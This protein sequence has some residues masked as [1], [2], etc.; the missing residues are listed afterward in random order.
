MI[1][2]STVLQ[3]RFSQ[4]I[5]E[6]KLF[7]PGDRLIVALSGGADSTALLHLLAN[8]DDFAP[9]LVVG[10]LNHCLRGRESDD[11]EVF[12]RELAASFNL[13][14]VT[15]RIDVKEFA[16]Q[17]RLNLEDAGR[18]ARADF[19]EEIRVSWQGTAIAVAHHG[20]DQAETVLM[21]L[22]RGAGPG[23]LRGMS[24]RNERRVIRPLLNFTRS[25]IETY[26]LEQ[27]LSYRKDSSNL[28]TSFLRN[29]IRH[30]LMPLL[31]DYNPAIRGR[32]NICAGQLS[33]EDDLL[34]QYTSALMSSCCK[35]EDLCASCNIDLLRK[36]HPA[37]RKRLY[38]LI[39]KEIA[40]SL[41]H[42][43]SL[44]VEAIDKLI[45][46]ERSNAMLNLP[47]KLTVVREYG[48][49]RFLGEV[50]TDALNETVISGPGHYKL[51]NTRALSLDHVSTPY[52]YASITADTAIFDLD[53]VPFPWRVRSF[54]NG[55]RIVPLGMNGSKKLKDLF[56]DCKVPVSQRRHTPLI[57]CGNN[58]IWTCGIR[59]SNHGKTSESSV[60][61]IKV[62]Y[63]H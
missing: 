16:R 9:R 28:D 37:L 8:L 40:G 5:R 48:C 47:Q 15:R 21:R 53:C 34:C 38:R 27:G 10:H 17:Q 11:D 1:S 60:N 33:D 25:E 30:E 29:R 61:L 22:L 63:T 51:S 13:P 31:E 3:T 6:K 62:V 44:H 4:N 50:Q 59:T 32:L 12:S 18:R 49:V 36:A 45:T 19:L 7:Q 57:F 56:I 39:F 41:D 2:A 42:L 14:F 43:T 52:D 54:R 26:L 46:S 20:D 58:L 24:F 23:G 35:W 55:D